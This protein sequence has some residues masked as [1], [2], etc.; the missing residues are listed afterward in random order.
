[1]TYATQLAAIAA[2]GATITNVG[3]IHT[4]PR[5]G[6]AHDHWVTSIDGVDVIRAWEIGLDEGGIRGDRVTEAHAGHYYQWRIQGYVGL[7][8]EAASY[9]DA[10][11]LAEAWRD[12]LEA[13]PTLSG[14]CLD[15]VGDNAGSPD[16]S[17]PVDL[18]IGGG[19]LCWGITIRFTTYEIASIP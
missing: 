13:N 11:T 1:M 5:Y 4:H 9:T 2:L 7:D 3:R 16:I 8:D 18:T 6:D 17:D 12:I 14:T 10:V 19:F 15:M